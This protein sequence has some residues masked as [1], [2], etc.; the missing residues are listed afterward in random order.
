M[1]DSIGNWGP[2]NSQSKKQA[3]RQTFQQE[4]LLRE[5]EDDIDILIKQKKKI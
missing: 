4:F 2:F 1:Q 3:T 5:K